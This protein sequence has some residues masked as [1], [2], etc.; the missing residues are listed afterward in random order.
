MFNVTKLKLPQQMEGLRCRR[1]HDLSNSDGET[2]MT[3]SHHNRQLDVR[4]QQ[5]FAPLSVGVVQGF[6]GLTPH[7]A[8]ASRNL[9]DAVPIRHERNT[10]TPDR[11]PASGEFVDMTL[12][13][14]NGQTT[15]RLMVV[16][17]STSVSIGTM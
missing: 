15:S 5:Y 10:S 7:R 6:D 12:S 16:G 1:L 3:T 11:E 2:L 13:Q 14:G 9:P 17:F 8:I 4:D